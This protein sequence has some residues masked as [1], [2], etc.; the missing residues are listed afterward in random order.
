MNPE[1]P[2]LIL[3]VRW[4]LLPDNKDA[5]HRKW[6]LC[7]DAKSDVESLTLKGYSEVQGVASV[8]SML[9]SLSLPGGPCQGFSSCGASPLRMLGPSSRESLYISPTSSRLTCWRKKTLTKQE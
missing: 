6:E 9:L 1:L 3:E 2:A 7:E 8:R 4:V 5:E